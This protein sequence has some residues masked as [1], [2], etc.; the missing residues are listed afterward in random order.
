MAQE[1]I[2]KVVVFDLN[3][4]FYNKSSKEEFYKFILKKRPNRFRY[5]FEMSYYYLKMKVNRIRQTEFKENF[6][7]YLD[8]LPPA[9]VEEYAR[10]FWAQEFPN[11]FNKELKKIFDDIKQSDTLL[12]C[13]TGGFELYVKPL[14]DIY[15]VDG[16]V[17]TIVKYEDDT[18]KLVGEAC[19]EEEKIRRLDQ[20]L[21]G[22]TYKIVE[23]YSDSKEVILDKAERAFYI[24]DKAILPYR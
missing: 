8:W 14:F 18:Y 1:E 12:I 6:F 5:V 16:L 4:T 19:K 2:I 20:L 7:N 13:A 11:E 3:G 21:K 24:K 10:E 22:K 15:K 9:K 17:G 23:A